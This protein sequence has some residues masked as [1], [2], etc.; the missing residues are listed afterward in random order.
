MLDCL[1]NNISLTF[2][3]PSLILSTFSARC[4]LLIILLI[5]FSEEKHHTKGESLDM[6]GLANFHKFGD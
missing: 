2:E 6:S 5:V 1:S 4:Q 3:F